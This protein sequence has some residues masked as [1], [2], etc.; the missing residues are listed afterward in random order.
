MKYEDI[1]FRCHSLAELMTEPKSKSEVLSVGAKTAVRKIA[2]QI[3]FGVR[4]NIRTKFMEKGLRCEQESID[5][6]SRVFQTPYVKNTERRENEWL[7]GE[8][9]IVMPNYGVD[10]KTSWS[11][12]TFPMLPED[13]D[14]KTYEWQCRG[15]MM[16]FDKPRWQVAYAL[17]DTPDDLCKW[18]DPVIHRVSH[19]PAILRVTRV[20]YDRDLELEEKI[21]VKAG[22]ALDHLKDILGRVEAIQE[23][24][25]D[26]SPS[27]SQWDTR[28][29]AQL[30]FSTPME[31]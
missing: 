20:V 12:D 13:G 21:K 19:I 30:A 5:L 6:I 3:V 25:G 14:D 2:K 16:L 9:D 4:G 7:T 23:L 17:V 22:H 11:I 15:Y 27:D 28:S 24:M 10:I 26:I 29:P 1:K 31:S 18:E 8:P